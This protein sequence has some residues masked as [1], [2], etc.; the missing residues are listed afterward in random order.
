MLD[1]QGTVLGLGL[2]H[3]C[4]QFLRGMHMTYVRRKGRCQYGHYNRKANRRHALQKRSIRCWR[5]ALRVC[6]L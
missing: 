1:M 2:L 5:I 4:Q 3:I 6:V